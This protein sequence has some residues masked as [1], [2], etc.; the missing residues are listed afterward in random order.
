MRSWKPTSV[1]GR[2]G[3]LQLPAPLAA[4]QHSHCSTSAPAHLHTLWLLFLADCPGTGSLGAPA[5]GREWDGVSRLSAICGAGKQQCGR[6]VVWVGEGGSRCGLAGGLRCTARD[7][8][9]TR[10]QRLR[11]YSR[12]LH[13]SP[14][15]LPP[16][17]PGPAASDL[18]VHL[19]PHSSC[20]AAQH[21]LCPC[22]HPRGAPADRQRTA[23][24]RSRCCTRR[25][26]C[27]ACALC[28]ST[29]PRRQLP[30]P[31]RSTKQRLSATSGE[32]RGRRCRAWPAWSH[33]Q[34]RDGA[35]EALAATCISPLPS[36][37][38]KARDW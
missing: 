17:P 3:G 28:R 26:K 38:H 4:A 20:L 24:S 11:S 10:V 35:G 32:P 23:C 19:R 1:F 16:R 7:S 33:K 15:P 18:F 27:G 25:W 5:D 2:S 14:L 30:G 9:K 21:S 13:A 29:R 8:N 37:C 12:A 22:L 34:A 36:T 31:T 6:C